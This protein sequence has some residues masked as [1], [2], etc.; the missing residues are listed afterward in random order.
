MKRMPNLTV[1]LDAELL[2]AAKVYAAQQQT[3]IS[4]IVHQRLAEL[5]G[6]EPRPAGDDVLARFARDQIGRHAATRALGDYG[7]LLELMAQ[8]GLALPRVPEQQAEA[9]AATFAEVWRSADDE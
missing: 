6:R 8:R 2:R 7:T 4:R 3:S 5:V 9:M 1:T